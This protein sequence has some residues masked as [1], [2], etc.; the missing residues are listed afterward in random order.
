MWKPIDGYFWPYRIYE[1]AEVQRQIGPDE[2]RPLS[3]SISRD[4]GHEYGRVFVRMRLA[5]GKYKNVFVKGLMVD[6]FMGG[7]RPGQVVI[8]KNG[9]MTDCALVNLAFSTRK[10]IGEQTGGASRRSVEKVDRDGNVVGLY[11]SVSEAAEKNY[12]SRKSIWMRCTHQVR[13]PYALDGY[14]Y[15][16]EE[17]RRYNGRK[18]RK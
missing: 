5:D 10:K 18:V 13:D 15:R 12:I 16:Y 4:T 7:K 2:W 3:H 14:D 17:P 1:E 6:A 8:F 11:S 9:M